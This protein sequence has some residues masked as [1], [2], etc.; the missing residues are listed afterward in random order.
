MVITPNHSL[1]TTC[2]SVSC[3]LS[4]ERYLSAVLDKSLMV[5]TISFLLSEYS[6]TS[7]KD[8][9]VCKLLAPQ[10]GI[11]QKLVDTVVCVYNPCAGWSQADPL[12]SLVSQRSPNGVFQANVRPCLQ[13]ENGWLLRNN[14]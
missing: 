10:A 14:I 5:E 8:D 1:Y 11:T 6:A 7:R 3:C 13:R 2:H 12:G 4:V 9:S